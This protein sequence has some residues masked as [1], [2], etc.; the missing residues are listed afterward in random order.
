MD[1]YVSES[2]SD[3][4]WSNVLEGVRFR[5][6]VTT[7]TDYSTSVANAVSFATTYYETITGVIDTGSSCL[8]LSYYM[9]ENF[10]AY[11]LTYLS[12]TTM[13]DNW[14]NLFNCSEIGNLPTIDLLLDGVWFEMIV[15]DYVVNFDGTTCAF[16]IT[17]SYYADIAILG[18]SFMRN[19]YFAFDFSTQ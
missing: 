8:V 7:T 19:Y 18:D 6:Q 12:S 9:Y 15:D 16:C 17:N 13:D 1:N 5:D 14:G 10:I 3:F 11:L 2:Y 4:W